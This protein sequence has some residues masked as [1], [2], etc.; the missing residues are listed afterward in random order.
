MMQTK[1]KAHKSDRFERGLH[2]MK[3]KKILIPFIAGA[4]AIS[5]AACSGD[6]K[7]KEDEAQSKLAE[8]QVDAKEIVAVV[9]DEELNGEQYNAALTSIQGQMQQMGQDPTSKEAAEQIKAQTLDTLVNQ[10]LLLQQAK[11]AEIEASKAEIDEEYEAFTKQFGDEEALKEV[12]ESQKMDVE[13]LKEQI[14]ESIV[15][16]KYTN[17]VAPAEEVTDE[18]IKEYYDLVA[19]QAKDSGQELPPLEEASE[20]IKGIL[21]QEQQ[22]KKLIAHVKELKEAAKIEL[23]I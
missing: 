20:E 1:L 18:E 13:A 14:A 21:E 10:T 22:Q 12:L 17:Q 19:A 9:N 16:N 7:A 4:L 3:F 5:L 6:D 11:D 2:K 23:K 8:Q 15:F